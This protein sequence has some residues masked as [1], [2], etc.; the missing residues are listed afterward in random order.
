MTD[1]ANAFAD[2]VVTEAYTKLI[3]VP[4]I[5]GPVALITLDNGFDHVYFHQIGPDQQPFFDA[6]RGELGDAV[7]ALSR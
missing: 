7:R 5:A 1:I 2:E 3:T 4:G 6:W